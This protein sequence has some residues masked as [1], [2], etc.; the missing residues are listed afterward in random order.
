[1]YTTSLSQIAL[2]FIAVAL[3]VVMVDQATR[4]LQAIM[5][6][7]PYLPDEFEMPIAYLILVTMASAICWLGHFDLFVLLGFIWWKYSFLGWILT[8]AII[9]GGSSLLGKQ[10]KMIGL[11]PSAISGMASTFGWGGSTDDVEDVIST[12]E[13]DQAGPL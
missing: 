7:I 1:M 12:P 11:I 2:A 10:F 9:A 5:I 3:L 4:V 13:S 8:G 6:K